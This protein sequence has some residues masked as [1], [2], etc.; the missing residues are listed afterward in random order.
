MEENTTGLEQKLKARD[1]ARGV[2]RLMATAIKDEFNFRKHPIKATLKTLFVGAMGA[3]IYFSVQNAHT[4]TYDRQLTQEVSILADTN[5]DRA[6]TSEEWANVYK[7]LGVR[8]DSHSSNP[9]ED[10]TTEQKENYIK[11]HK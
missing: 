1:V 10:L 7:E 6:T 2:G 5:K 11:N 9:F 3:G 4:E 8:Y